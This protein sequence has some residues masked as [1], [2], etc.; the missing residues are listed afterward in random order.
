M[1]T[2]V[3][4]LKN[5]HF[6]A[7]GIINNDIALYDDPNNQDLL[8]E[9]DDYFK[10]LKIIRGNLLELYMI[11]KFKCSHR[12]HYIVNKVLDNIKLFF[13]ENDNPTTDI[14]KLCDAEKVFWDLADSVEYHTNKDFSGKA[15]VKSILRDI[16]YQNFE[17]SDNSSIPDFDATKDIYISDERFLDLVKKNLFFEVIE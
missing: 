8:N 9:R 5:L 1:K 13:D 6:I 16:I 12:F 15:E 10:N 14:S 7:A 3:N 2:K 11:T 4:V 17:Y